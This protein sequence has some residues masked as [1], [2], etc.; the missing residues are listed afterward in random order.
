MYFYPIRLNN[1]VYFGFKQ[2]IRR[3]YELSS[4]SSIITNCTSWIIIN[5]SRYFENRFWVSFRKRKT[6]KNAASLNVFVILIYSEC[7]SGDHFTEREQKQIASETLE[8]RKNTEAQG[9]KKSINPK[10]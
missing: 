7:D 4:V 8:Q 5:S 1:C 2:K 3:T 9:K 10:V 6:K